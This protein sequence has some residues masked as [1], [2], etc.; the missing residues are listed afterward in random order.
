MKNKNEKVTQIPLDRFEEVVHDILK[1]NKE[2]W[3]HKNP[4]ELNPIN[5]ESTDYDIGHFSGINKGLYSLVKGLDIQNDMLKF[6]LKRRIR[7]D[8][9]I[10]KQEIVERTGTCTGSG[11]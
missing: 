7:I 8:E 3:N 4:T 6:S 11:R 2:M 5:G 10:G 1:K 9:K